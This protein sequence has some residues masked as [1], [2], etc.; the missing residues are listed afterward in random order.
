[1]NHAAQSKHLAAQI[2]LARPN[3][4]AEVNA[5][6]P[7]ANAVASAANNN[8]KHRRGAN[9]HPFFIFKKINL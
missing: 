6:A 5:K 7:T 4:L 1:M 8:Q 2:Q 3:A 9:Q